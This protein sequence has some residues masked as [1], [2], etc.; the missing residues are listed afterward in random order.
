MRFK[1]RSVADLCA[2]HDPL[3]NAD[4]ARRIVLTAHKKGTRLDSADMVVN[5]FPESAGVLYF[6]EVLDVFHAAPKGKSLLQDFQNDAAYSVGGNFH[7]NLEFRQ[8]IMDVNA[9]VFQT[10]LVDF[11]TRQPGH[12]SRDVSTRGLYF[13]SAWNRTMS[14]QIFW[15]AAG[16]V[17]QGANLPEFDRELKLEKAVYR[18]MA[19]HIELFPLFGQ[20]NSGVYGFFNAPDVSDYTYTVTSGAT[21]LEDMD[22]EEAVDCVVAFAK[23]VNKANKYVYSEGGGGLDLILSQESFDSLSRIYPLTMA[24][25]GTLESQQTL[26]DRIMMQVGRN[27]K[28][29]KILGDI[30][31]S[32]SL[33]DVDYNG[34]ASV[35][36][37]IALGVP[38]ARCNVAPVDV[39]DFG[40]P[41]DSESLE[42]FQ[43]NPFN[44]VNTLLSAAT[45]V[46]I[47]QGQY[48]HRMT[49]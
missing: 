4:V 7:P 45:G 5:G 34:A 1:T 33:Q 39:A 31:A 12:A 13:A 11:E 48:I 26:L 46:R 40:I 14:E 38:N 21:R 49:F 2:M 35:G 24:P 16:Q 28:G 27:G 32:I 3:F 37:R 20:P 43:V 18:K 10:N 41:V 44:W 36:N 19:E 30:K 23:A 25:S 15:E 8:T 42:E 29:V 6:R 9:Q 47:K 17:A 22:P